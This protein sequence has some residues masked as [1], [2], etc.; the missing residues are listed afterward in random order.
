MW[1]H[2]YWLFNRELASYSLLFVLSH[3]VCVY[4]LQRFANHII[5]SLTIVVFILQSSRGLW[6]EEWLAQELEQAGLIFKKIRHIRSFTCNKS[7]KIGFN[8]HF[9]P[10][11]K[12]EWAMYAPSPN[13]STLNQDENYAAKAKELCSLADELNTLL[14]PSQIVRAIAVMKTFLHQLISRKQE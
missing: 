13:S 1:K 4:V 7:D 2:K 10:I 12:S 6:I 14:L 11:N 3:Y 8:W 5:S 9:L